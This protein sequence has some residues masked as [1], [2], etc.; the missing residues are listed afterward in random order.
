MA[1]VP[2]PLTLAVCAEADQET[3]GVAPALLR[4]LDG[5]E[6]DA[7]PGVAPPFF[8]YVALTDGDGLTDLTLA[9]TE[10][11]PEVSEVFRG[12][13]RVA[14]A[15]RLGVF[16]LCLLVEGCFFPRP[17]SY[18]LALSAGDE[19]LARRSIRVHPTEGLP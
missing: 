17:G 6:L 18:D 16:H 19:T 15:G 10:W 4:I 2:T 8:V 1:V 7:L 5:L 9:V 3:P 14:L 12:S 11:G 13:V